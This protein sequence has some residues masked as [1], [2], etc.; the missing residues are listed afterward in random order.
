MKA[1]YYRFSF[2]LYMLI[3]KNMILYKGDVFY[4][5]KNILIIVLFL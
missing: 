5:D 2:T 1:S 4:I 3:K